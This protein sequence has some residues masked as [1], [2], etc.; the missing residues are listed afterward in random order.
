MVSIM[1]NAAS[2]RGEEGEE[3]DTTSKFNESW[4]GSG[5]LAEDGIDWHG[6]RR[7]CN[8]G[9]TR[10]HGGTAKPRSVYNGECKGCGEVTGGER[11]G[12][13]V[14][15]GSSTDR[16]EE[17]LLCNLCAIKQAVGRAARDGRQEGGG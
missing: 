7:C 6:A 12:G 8:N 16:E 11:Q 2:N 1:A 13:M 17:A 14:K 5:Q 4:P 3:G 10:R 15:R 9:G